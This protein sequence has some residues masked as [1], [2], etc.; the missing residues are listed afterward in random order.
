MKTTLQT[1][2]KQ[3]GLAYIMDVYE[4]IPFEN[5]AQYLQATLNAEQ[6]GR[7]RQV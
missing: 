7:N 4:T 1:L 2:C 3:M 5:P 6:S